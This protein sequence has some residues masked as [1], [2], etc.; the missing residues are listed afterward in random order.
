MVVDMGY[1]A[2]VGKR[3]LMFII[4]IVAIYLSFKCAV[5]YMP[6][7]IAGIISL[8]IEPLIKF[9]NKKTKLTRKTSA[10]IVLI[11]VFSLIIGLLVWGITSLILEASDL[12]NGLNGYYDKAYIQV[13]NI[14]NSIDL[15]KINVSD[16]VT[17]II[18][19]S[20]GD[21]LK[22]VSNWVTN[23]LHSLMNV[24]T[25]IPTIAIYVVVTLLAIYFICT[26]KLYLVDQIEHHLPKLWVKRMGI[27]FRELVASL[28]NYLKAEVTLVLIDFVI[29]L[30]GLF[31]FQLVGFNIEYPLLAALVIA[32]VDALPILGAGTA[33]VPWA[34]VSAINGDI[35]LAIAL[36]ILYAVI[37]VLR[38]FLEPKIVSKHIGIHPIFTLIAM[39][40]GFKFIGVIGMLLGPIILIIL[41]NIFK[42]LIDQG[43][44]KT[45]LDQK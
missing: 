8:L 12:L 38:Q 40:T 14:I 2:K 44:V 39:Y 20:T 10:I 22:T 6:F 27:H 35:R 9:V 5:F 23:A 19:N 34:V 41:K 42:T 43:F 1:W 26:D 29:V 33:M 15:E 30:I 25:S 7:L 4:S 11:V 17:N 3:L 16:E 31:I 13:Q 18:K 36:L 28:G 32:F 21:F 37:L 24:I 45:I